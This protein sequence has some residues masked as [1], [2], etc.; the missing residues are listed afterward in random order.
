MFIA[1]MK[2]LGGQIN[3]ILIFGAN[4]VTARCLSIASNFALATKGTGSMASLL[5]RI[6]TIGV[7]T[8]TGGL[9]RRGFVPEADKAANEVSVPVVCITPANDNFP[10]LAR[11]RIL[12]GGGKLEDNLE[13]VS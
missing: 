1:L 10:S 3:T 12:L 8:Y 2:W 7:S 11:W 6:N 9:L 4:T 13:I 5:E